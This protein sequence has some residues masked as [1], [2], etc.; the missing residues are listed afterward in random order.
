MKIKTR[1]YLLSFVSIILM[2]MVGLITFQAIGKINRQTEIKRQVATI[3]RG[4]SELNL[5]SHEYLRY[6]EERMEKQWQLK[7]GALGQALKRLEKGCIHP[8]LHGELH[9]SM[10][11]DFKQVGFLFSEI[12]AVFTNRKRLMAEN[13]PRS[14]I[15][16]ALIKE[17]MI[18]DQLMITSRL[19]MS[20]TARLG[21][22]LRD[23]VGRAQERTKTLLLF[24]IAGFVLLWG[25]ASLFTFR[26]ITRSMKKLLEGTQRIGK[27]DLNHR[28]DVKGKDEIGELASAFNAMTE[29]RRQA[30]SALLKSRDELE[31]RVKERTDELVVEIRERKQAQE[32]TNHLNLVLRAIRDVNQLITKEADP[33]RLIERACETLV[34]SRGYYHA[35]IVLLDNARNLVFAAEAGIGDEFSEFLEILKGGGLTECGMKT[36]KQSGVQVVEKPLDACKNCPLAVRY[37]GRSALKTR[38]AHGD[39]IYGIMAV[40]VPA[41]MAKD[42]EE[43]AIFSEVGN[44]IAFALHA[45]ASE[46]MK[47]EAEEKS[48]A[49]EDRFR[50]LFEMAPDAFYLNDMEGRFIDGNKASENLMGYKREELI[51]KNLFEAGLLPPDQL[52]KAAQLLDESLQG[53]P[54]GPVE[55]T[56][57]RKDGGQIHVEIS[58]VPATI[59]GQN[60]VLGIARD[61][62]QRKAR[63]EERL[64]LETQLQQA[65]K[66]EAIGTLAGGIAHDF[67]NIL[68]VIIGYS[69][70]AIVDA[71]EGSR[72]TTDLKTVL[73]AGN[74]ARR[75]VQQ[76]LSFSR[77]GQQERVPISINPVIKESL[78][79]LR[80]SLPTS[81]EIRDVIETDPGIIEGDA[82]QIHQIMMNL[83]TNAQH[84]MEEEGG[85]L[86][87]RLAR[88]VVDRQ[89]ASRHHDLH[90]GPYLQLT[91]TDTGC[92]MD[93]KTVANIFDPYFTTKGLGEGTGLGMS[94][95]HGIVNTHGGAVTVESEPGKGTTFHVYFPIIE[96][97]EETQE[98]TEGPLPTGNER[99]LWV[100]DEPL[101]VEIG[102]EI[103]GPLGYDVVTRTSS[104]EALALF[105][106]DPDRFDLVVTDM[107][108][109]H[110]TGDKLARE[111]MNI[112]PAIPII[113]CTGFNK[114]ISE[115][116]AEEIGIRA[117]LMKPLVRKDLAET[118]RKVLGD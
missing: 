24:S 29:K 98:E 14:K 74:R 35:W 84:A 70:I 69:E 34:S 68:S 77:I 22:M 49:S 60:M 115:N 18:A 20:E 89:K 59:S 25:C 102:R 95:V 15:D 30:V 12:Q 92:G 54:T 101:I 108:M 46:S 43:L 87:V 10:V 85:I 109:P 23:E 48:K 58:T 28:V 62:T 118:V 6:H 65:Q 39:R 32:R 38:L 3:T 17:N 73:N 90:T 78:R 94:V 26:A 40:S 8:G 52:P 11:R 9:A 37:P 64:K 41:K 96:R 100:D 21:T 110:M 47:I 36:V 72:L 112:R 107:T 80:A 4:L 104:V 42:E 93:D 76:I 27:G 81:I 66:M 13:S 63:E 105:K 117:F 103:L 113:L 99:I 75:L 91:V 97:D 50:A 83:C 55:L 1:L 114:M 56:L 16:R 111:M 61:V 86:D 51:G 19:M 71:P 45:M 7:Y 57:N 116:K 67:N 5:I 53:R 31:M 88:V 2:A 44:D 33:A 79:F 106:T 82:T